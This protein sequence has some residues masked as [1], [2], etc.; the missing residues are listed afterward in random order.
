M[1]W[2]MG[3]LAIAIL[4]LAATHWAVY[5][6]GILNGQK[7]FVK[8]GLEMNSEGTAG[9]FEMQ[10]EY[11]RL[12]AAHPDAISSYDRRRT[13]RQIESIAKLV[14]TTH[15]IIKRKEGMDSVA[16]LWQNKISE[17][18]TLTTQLERE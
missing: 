18:R 8:A 15:V 3:L 10:L 13:C 5:R 9:V 14:E 16:K 4:V 1:I 6:L 7:Q 12:L 17:A 11:L 2:S